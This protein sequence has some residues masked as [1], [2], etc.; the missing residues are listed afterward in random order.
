MGIEKRNLQYIS[1]EAL[2]VSRVLFEVGGIM[3]STNWPSTYR[4]TVANE[5]AELRWPRGN[6]GSADSPRSA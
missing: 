6:L 3:R 1:S 4:R 5:T 2:D